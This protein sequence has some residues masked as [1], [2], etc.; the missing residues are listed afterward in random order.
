MVNLKKCILRL[1]NKNCS[2]A[3]LI[4]FYIVFASFKYAVAFL[5]YQYEFGYFKSHNNHQI[6]HAI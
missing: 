1:R 3:N 5:P 2:H 6:A 4:T